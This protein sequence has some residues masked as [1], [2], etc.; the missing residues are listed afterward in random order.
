M[1]SKIF[2]TKDWSY[3]LQFEVFTNSLKNSDIKVYKNGFHHW[4]DS[5]G[6]HFYAMVVHRLRIIFFKQDKYYGNG[7]S[8]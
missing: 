2:H 3:G 8:N 7:I 5:F 6:L 1:A 4:M